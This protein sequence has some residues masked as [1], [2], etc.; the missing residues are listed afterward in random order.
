VSSP[1]WQVG[2]AIRRCDSSTS[3]QHVQHRG[4]GGNRQD[5][6][7]R[8]DAR[9]RVVDCLAQLL[10][11]DGGQYCLPT[12]R[13]LDN[14]TVIRTAGLVHH[15]LP[16]SIFT[17]CL[18]RSGPLPA[19]RP[20]LTSEQR[21][22]RL[23]IGQPRPGATSLASAAA[24]ATVP[25]GA[26][27]AWQQPTR[28]ASH[29]GGTVANGKLVRRAKMA[30]DEPTSARMAGA[31]WEQASHRPVRGRCRARDGWCLTGAA[32]ADGCRKR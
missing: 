19:S 7:V 16:V 20:V 4:L 31:G 15:S 8:M 23:S 27:Q 18:D 26:W 13:P 11:T 22:K 14:S 21:A 24:T 30:L 12:R 2:Q 9:Q 28:M 29:G 17:G 32:A 3:V 10:G 5:R 25:G 1:R 6:R